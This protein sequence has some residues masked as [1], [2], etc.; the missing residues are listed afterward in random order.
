LNVPT[1]DSK[2]WSR[3]DGTLQGDAISMTM[4]SVVFRVDGKDQTYDRNQVKK[5][6]LVQ[7]ETVQHQPVVQPAAEQH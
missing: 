7:R 3:V 1:H 2:I 4:T 5:I 6:T